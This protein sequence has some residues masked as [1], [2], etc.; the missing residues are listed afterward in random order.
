TSVDRLEGED[1]D[2]VETKTDSPAIAKTSQP[3]PAIVK[4]L[5]NVPEPVPAA[6]IP[7]NEVQS[8][9]DPPLPKRV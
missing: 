6:H 7:D 1:W 9:E 8:D 2:L 5:S 3:A 4:P